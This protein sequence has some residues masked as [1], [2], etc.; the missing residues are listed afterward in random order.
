M[1]KRKGVY[2]S[3]E[4]LRMLKLLAG[5][6]KMSDV[7]RDAVL[8]FIEGGEGLV[9]DIPKTDADNLVFVDED[10]HYLINRLKVELSYRTQDD[11]L[12]DVLVNYLVKKGIDEECL[13]KILNL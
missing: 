7:I 10:V 8:E 11:F 5:K 13:V 9:L 12:F 2:V 4:T 1:A 3:D 6:K